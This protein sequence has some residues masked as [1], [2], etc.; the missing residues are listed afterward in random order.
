[1]TSHH[2]NANLKANYAKF[3]AEL[4]ALTRK[5][6]VAVKSVGGVTLARYDGEF[7]SVS[8]VGDIDSGD[9]TPIFSSV[10]R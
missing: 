7:S 5:Y 10:D 6:G 9:V 4:A 8:Y 3:L 2:F 1:M